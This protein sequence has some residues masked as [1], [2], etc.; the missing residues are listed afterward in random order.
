MLSEIELPS[1]PEDDPT[2][3]ADMNDLS[4]EPEEKE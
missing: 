2:H 4:F 1:K 3:E